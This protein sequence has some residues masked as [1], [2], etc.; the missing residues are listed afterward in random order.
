MSPRAALRLE[1][2]GFRHVYDYTAG[3]ADWL[4]AGLPSER[5]EARGSDGGR[6]IDA[7]QHVPTC[8]LDDLVA[9]ARAKAQK[10]DADHCV[11][12]D[13]TGVVHGRVRFGD[14]VDVDDQVVVE[15]AMELGP[16]TVRAD[17]P[18]DALRERMAARDVTSVL[19]TTPDGC[20][21]GAVTRRPGPS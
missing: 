13:G 9:D 2:L 15:E 5:G 1:R 7:A 18:L 20:L 4:A 17:E 6:A 21:L 19:V 8:Q 16:T 11:V 3:K 14:R 10:L 12:V